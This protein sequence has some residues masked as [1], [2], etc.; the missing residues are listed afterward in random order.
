MKWWGWILSLLPAGIGV[1]IY[2][3]AANGMIS[4]PVRSLFA[5]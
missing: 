3:L 4:D 2:F 5:G 1:L